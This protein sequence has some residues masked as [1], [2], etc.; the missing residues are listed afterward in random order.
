MTPAG[1][2]HHQRTVAI[3]GATGLIG[4]ALERMLIGRGDTVRRIVRDRPHARA[5]D[6]VWNPTA[7][8][9]DEQAMA[10]VDAVI[11]L[12]GEP[13]AHRWTA[14]RKAAIRDSRVQGTDLLART[15]A[16]MPE[17][18]RVFLSGSAIGIY[19][20]A[21]AVVVDERSPAGEGFLATVC[22]EW[23]AAA[24][25]VAAAGIRTVYLRTGVVLSGEGG[26]LATLLPPFKL[27]LGGPIGSGDQWVSWISLE[28]ECRAILHALDSP[29][30]AGPVNLVAPGA[31]TN[32]DF[33]HALGSALHRPTLIPIPGFALEL[34]FGEMADE[35]ILSGQHVVPRVL[36]GAGFTFAHPALDVALRA[37]LSA[38]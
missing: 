5:G 7:G 37:V 29:A 18:P 21:G 15:L 17:S 19:G 28:D 24:A 23:E 27:G 12:A 14:K 6:V 3:S 8:T 11:H 32:A 10:G 30:L 26:M 38:R 2:S 20:D 22:E 13:I 4:S 9:I 1:S 35:T 33:V 31:V 36:N 25:P 34:V 16:R